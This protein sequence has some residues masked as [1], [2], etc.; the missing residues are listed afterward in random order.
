ML[1][2]LLTTTNG[3]E[4]SLPVLGSL[5]HLITDNKDTILLSERFTLLTLRSV[6]VETLIDAILPS[7]YSY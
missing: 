6:T 1:G 3:V 2:A 5:G 4:A 7:T